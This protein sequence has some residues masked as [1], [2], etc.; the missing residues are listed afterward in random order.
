M[1]DKNY[2]ILL[3]DA[4]LKMDKTFALVEASV[5]KLSQYEPEKHYSF[6][7]LEPYDAL[8]DR[9]IRCVEMFVKYFKTYDTYQS[10]NGALTF[11]DLINTMEKLGLVSNTPIWMDMKDV[12]NRIVHDYLPKQTKA[13][14]DS[15]MSEFYTELKYSKA[16]IQTIA[17]VI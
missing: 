10:I 13:M 11:R 6:D 8:T 17:T 12:R 5:S 7:E 3:E 14:F 9:F 15:I 4:K 2:K 1:N 16:R